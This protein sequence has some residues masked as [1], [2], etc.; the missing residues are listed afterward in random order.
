MMELEKEQAV[1]N[2]VKEA[3]EDAEADVQRARRVR[4]KIAPNRVF[5]LV[6][7]L[8]ANGFNHFVTITAVDWIKDG[9]IELIYHLWSYTRKVHV[10]VKTRIPRDGGKMPTLK[11]LFNQAETYERD[12]HE[13]FGVYFEGNEK[14]DRD[15]IL[16]DWDGPPP[17]RKDFD[18]RRF[19]AEFYGQEDIE[20]DLLKLKIQPYKGKLMQ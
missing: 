15:F 2:L 10:M 14:L 11:P 20:S 19:A 12:V 9:E 1:V 7:F 6:A 3:F 13:F 5:P 17:M 16:E 4:I 8:K 18:T